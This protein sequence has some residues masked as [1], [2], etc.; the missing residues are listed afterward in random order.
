[1]THVRRPG[2]IDLL[3]RRV[4]R[5]PPAPEF[6]THCA[7][8]DVLR[9]WA[10]PEWRWTHIAS[11]EYRSKATAARLQRMGVVAGYPDFM[12]IGPGGQVHFIELKRARAPLTTAQ[13]DFA[14]WCARNRVP[15]AVARSFDEA[16]RI[17]KVWGAVRTGIEVSA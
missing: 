10:N 6:N 17:L 9:R 4:S 11:G 7:V 1:M 5:P 16:L 2:Q 14:E 12:L 8:A 15:H 3:T 13:K